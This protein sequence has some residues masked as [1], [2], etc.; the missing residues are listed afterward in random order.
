MTRAV[1]CARH[2]AATPAQSKAAP[3]A[4]GRATRSRPEV[5]RGRV[6]SGADTGADTRGRDAGPRR[7]LASV[8]RR[9]QDARHLAAHRPGLRSNCTSITSWVRT[10][11]VAAPR[12]KA[13]ALSQ[14]PL[15]VGAAPRATPSRPRRRRRPPAPH[16]PPPVAVQP[17]PPLAPIAAAP[18]TRPTTKATAATTQPTH[19]TTAHPTTTSPPPPPITKTP[20]RARACTGPDVEVELARWPRPLRQGG[21]RSRPGGAAARR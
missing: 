20:P 5:H 9:G 19:P 2:D 3:S 1:I 14:A 12:G 7:G 10:L 17:T 6:A 21:T 18:T 13:S 4:T 11:T 15:G 8:E 16:T